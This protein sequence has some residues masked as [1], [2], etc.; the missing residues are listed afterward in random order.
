MLFGDYFLICFFFFRS[1]DSLQVTLREKPIHSRVTKVLLDIC[2]L[3][4]QSSGER[5]IATKCE[6]SELVSKTPSLCDEVKHLTFNQRSDLKRIERIVCYGIGSPA[7][8]SAARVQTAL[9]VEISRV[10]NVLRVE[11]YDPAFCEEDR[12]LFRTLNFEIVEQNEGCRREVKEDTL[13]YMIHCS[14]PMYNNLLWKNWSSDNLSK[15]IIIGNNFNSL[16]MNVCSQK[17]MKRR[18]WFVYTVWHYSM[19]SCSDVAS[20]HASDAFIDTAVISFT[21]DRFPAANSPILD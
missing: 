8:S 11:V 1:I 6:N 15:L 17:E 4:L 12:S 19:C 2:E 13:F 5:D 18:H 3:P 9:L 10:L 20:K 21:R 14:W 16:N 7:T